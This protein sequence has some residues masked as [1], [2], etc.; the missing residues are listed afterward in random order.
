MKA[1]P[2]PRRMQTARSGIFQIPPDLV[3]KF[4]VIDI[5]ELVLCQIMR[6]SGV[7]ERKVKD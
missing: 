6:A 1:R 5:A 3:L 2:S 7:Y 4:Q